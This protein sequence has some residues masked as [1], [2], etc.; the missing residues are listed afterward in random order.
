MPIC[1]ADTSPLIAFSGIDRLDVLRAVFDEV[2]VPTMVFAE[3]V[4]QGVGWLEAA[5]VQREL[6][7]GEWMRTVV[8]Q[9]SSILTSLCTELGVCG[10]A[11]AICLSLNH[12]MPVLLDELFGRKVAARNGAE[13]IGSLGVLKIAKRKGI[14]S[15]AGTLITGMIANGIHFK[16]ELISQFL[17]E[18]GEA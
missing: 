17:T 15:N 8:V 5:A 6:G 14:I 16:A 11:E 4:T 13:V 9:P 12:R 2:W 1:A 10:E 7:K 18:L 3:M